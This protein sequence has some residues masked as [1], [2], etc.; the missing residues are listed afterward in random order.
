MVKFSFVKSIPYLLLLVFIVVCVIA[1]TG[2]LS[3]LEQ[4]PSPIYGGDIYH[5]LG[6]V[7]HV[8]QGGNVFG[9]F[10]TIGDS[11]SAYFPLFN[12]VV[13]GS[14]LLFGLTSFS[15]VTL[16][17]VLFFVLSIIVIFFLVKELFGDAFVALLST[18]FVVFIPL[19]TFMK[20]TGL[21]QFIVFPLFVLLLVRFYKGASW[22]NTLLLGL[23]YGLC[24][25]AHGS[26]FIAASLLFACFGIFLVVGCFSKLS[27]NK[28]ELVLKVKK[29]YKFI[30][31]FLVGFLLSLLYWLP[32]FKVFGN[33]PNK[34]TEWGQ[35]NYSLGIV[36]LGFVGKFLQVFFSPFFFPLFG[37]IL[38]FFIKKNSIIKF[39]VISGS[40]LC[41]HFFVS[42]PLFG[43]EFSPHYMLDFFNVII[44]V[45]LIGLLLHFLLSFIKNKVFA[46]VLIVIIS[47]LLVMI[48]TVPVFNERVSDDRW[49]SVGETVLPEFF[50][51]GA[52]W[53]NN[54]TN[55]SDGFV[56][57]KEL[58]SAVNAL[59]GRRFISIRRNQHALTS[60]VDER[61]LDLA[62]LLY[63]NDNSVRDMV[64]DKYDIKYLY[65]N[66]YWFDSE[67]VVVN[68]SLVDFFDPIMLMYNTDVE[69]TLINNNI[70]YVFNNMIVDSAKRNEP[71][72]D[73]FDVLIVLPSQRGVFNPWAKELD[74]YL[75]PVWDYSRDN[76]T[77]S[78]IY[79]VKN[80]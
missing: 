66:Y 17:S 45:I 64:I 34:V 35:V 23:V 33:I 60:E 37:L 46:R 1:Y 21:A 43:L 7:E 6:G 80:G 9:G 41:F 3:G 48:V 49:I 50:S 62:L 12:I 72:V 77:Y 58:G 53:I 59:T 31:S 79:E 20:Y 70:S 75:F 67:F 4:A 74:D 52:E 16:F 13:G 25:L 76:V 51:E 36:Q 68:N 26:A 47:V 54:N 55:L 10:A 42:I 14:A 71:G 65:W 39:L 18:V 15:A 78:I 28:V 2:M 11:V 38:L 30:V 24:G 44:S 57:T 22:V 32:V 63:S 5:Q 56:S 69:N 8:R 40:L 19:T 29:Y 27:F 73:S 61:E